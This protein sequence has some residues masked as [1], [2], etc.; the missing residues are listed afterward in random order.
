MKKYGAKYKDNVDIITFGDDV[1]TLHIVQS[2]ELDDELTLLLQE[3][4]NNYL[5]F[6]LDGQLFEEYPKSKGKE[7][8]IEI[9]LKFPPT[10]LAAKFL[11]RSG[12]V[13]ESEGLG[14]KV[15]VKPADE[16]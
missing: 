11:D 7:L 13:V 2:E 12:P 9:T 4:I 14:F 5:S 16:E 6:A 8:N 1:C 3:K 15:T 10:G